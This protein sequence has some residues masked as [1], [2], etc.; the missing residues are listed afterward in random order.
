MD[1]RQFVYDLVD[2]F[3]GPL[4]TPARWVADRVFGVWDDVSNVFRMTV[5]RWRQWF[6]AATGFANNLVDAVAEAAVTARWIVFQWAPQFV[7]SKVDA[8]IS[9]ASARIGEARDFAR[10]LVNGV[11]DW[12]RAQVN[13]ALAFIAGVR[14]WAVERVREVWATL[15]TVARLVG[16]LLTDPSKLATW[17]A[18]AMFWALLRVADGLIEP[19]VDYLWARRQ[20][21]IM[22]TLSRIEAIIARLL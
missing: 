6:D 3:P 22:R 7:K 10:G 5:P 20:S 12:T 9:W 15:S 13:E 14:N 16:D 4:K 21:V 11:V 8:A 19:I 17:V 18:G 1:V 2:I